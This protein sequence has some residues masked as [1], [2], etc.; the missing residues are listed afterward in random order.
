MKKS[1]VHAG[2]LLAVNAIVTVA[3][4][5]VLPDQVPVHFG[6]S[7]AA[8]RIGSKYE[9]LSLLATALI[10][11]IVLA[12]CGLFGKGSNRATM[13]RLAVG[14]QAIFILVGLFIFLNQLRYDGNAATASAP[15]FDMSQISAIVIGSTFLLMGYFMPR[16]T[17]NAVFGIRVPWTQ[18]SDEAW[19]RAH[20]F[21]GA[22]TVAAGTMI[23][24]AGVVLKGSAAFIALAVIFIAWTLA[25]LIGSYVACRT[26]DPTE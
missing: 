3:F 26:I 11:G 18:K 1:L 10:L 17:R 14:M 24:L 8:D 23:V 5:C 12:L 9:N 7:G 25:C 20:R 13:A 21:G 22:V 16:S 19:A 15:D 2:I 6:A 4:L